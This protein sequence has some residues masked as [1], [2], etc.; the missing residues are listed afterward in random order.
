M[1]NLQRHDL[2]QETYHQGVLETLVLL[3]Q[4][5]DALGEGLIGLGEAPGVASKGQDEV[6]N[7]IAHVV[8]RFADEVGFLLES[9]GGKVECYS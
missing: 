1:G 6:G 9:I 8:E 2:N 7:R 4:L 3:L 5:V